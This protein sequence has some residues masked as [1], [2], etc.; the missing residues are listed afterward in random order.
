MK[1]IFELIDE[2]E[3]N[4]DEMEEMDVS[5]FER[6]KIKN[7]IKRVIKKKKRKKNGLAVAA[8]CCA[9]I[10]SIGTLGIV[11]PTYAADI[12]IVGDIFRFLDNGKTGVY[13][14]Y[15]EN[16]NEINMTKEDKGISI[17]IRDAVFEGNRITYTYEIKSNMDLG[18]NPS[19]TG[20]EVSGHEDDGFGESSHVQ[21]SGTNTYVGQCIATYDDEIKED[22]IKVKIKVD[23]IR[24]LIG[25]NREVVE[26]KWDFKFNL[27]RVQGIDKVVN[28]RTQK[29]GIT[30]SINKIHKTPMSFTI[31]YSTSFDDEIVNKLIDKNASIKEKTRQ[32][33]RAACGIKKMLEVRDDLGNIY[34]TDLHGESSSSEDMHNIITSSI[35][36]Q[37]NP[38]AS[39]LIITPKVSFRGDGEITFEDK[40]DDIFFNG[41]DLKGKEIV[42]DDIVVD[43]EK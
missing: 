12:P 18:K 15:K 19:I 41:D 1:D 26:G 14:K 36:G 6:E 21:K 16:S 20:I 8:V 30:C 22:D 17:T 23:K 33:A 40:D 3:V 7:N 10:G 37:L 35:F 39:Q 25:E 31:E 29:E 11:N 4:E 27:H 42:F 5:E 24:I 28:Q 13:D 2:I 9:I 43:L 38:N 34:N 32:Q